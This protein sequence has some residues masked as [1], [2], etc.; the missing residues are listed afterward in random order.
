MGDPAR[1][2][3]A[4]IP[5]TIAPSHPDWLLG[6][7]V[8]DYDAAAQL[9]HENLLDFSHLAYVHANS[10]EAGP[11]WADSPMRSKTLERGVRFER[12]I[13]NSV[14]PGYLGGSDRIDGYITYDYLIPGILTMWS[15]SF[16]VGTA[17]QFDF[18]R[19]DFELAT[20]HVNYTAQAITPLTAGTSRYW[21]CTGPTK[22]FGTEELRD[23]NVATTQ[24]AFA[25]DKSMIEGQQK[26]MD[27]TDTI[28]FM[29]ISHDRGATMYA[30]V[31]RRLMK[32]AGEIAS[33]VKVAVNG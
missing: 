9:I 27:R 29:P 30:G 32:E 7:G 24:A 21:F 31:V 13:P 28:R 16:P 3:P 33:P 23:I 6:R 25:E 22:R 19:P 18:G 17:Q 15:G 8:I 11:E 26:I 2:D 5:D 1:A 14:M 20:G 10:F 12:W 4:L